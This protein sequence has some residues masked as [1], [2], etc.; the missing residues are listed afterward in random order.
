[1]PPAPPQPAPAQSALPSTDDLRVYELFRERVV[2]EDAI[3]N[4]RMTWMFWSQAIILALWGALASQRLNEAVCKSHDLQIQHALLA[5]SVI[6]VAFSLIS[7]FSVFAA[8]SEINNIKRAYRRRYP[9]IYSNDA[10]PKLTGESWRHFTGHLV[11]MFATGLLCALWAYFAY[12]ALYYCTLIPQLI[13]NALK[14]T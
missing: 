13:T 8:K 3:I 14:T 7:F 1:M 4:H 11:D 5:L 10:I 12:Y 9:H 2:E 6:G